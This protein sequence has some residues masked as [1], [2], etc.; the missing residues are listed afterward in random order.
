M[1]ILAFTKQYTVMHNGIN[2]YTGEYKSIHGTF[3]K[4][5]I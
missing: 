2:D 3:M 4:L 5:V 1:F